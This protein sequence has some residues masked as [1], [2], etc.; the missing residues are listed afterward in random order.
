MRDLP[1]LRHREPGRREVLH[2]VRDAVRRSPARAA[3]RRTCPRPSSAPSAP[4]R[5]AGGAA[6]ATAAAPTAP[7]PPRD[8]LPSDAVAER[9]LVSVLFADLVG[10]TAFSEGRDAEEVR[11]L[12]DRYFETVREVIG[13]YGGTVEKFIGDAVMALWGAPIAHEDDAERAV[14]AGLDLVD[15]VRGSG[16]ALEVRAGVLTGEAAVTLGATEPGHG[17]RRHGQHGE[18]A[19][20]RRAAFDR[21][22]RRGDAARR[23]QARSSSSPPADQ[24]LKGKAEPGPRLARPAGRR[25][26]RRR[27]ADSDTLEAPFVGRDEELRQLKDLFHATGREG[28]PRLVSVIGPAGIGKSRL[29]WEFLKYVD[30]LVETRLVARRPEPGLRRGDHVLGARRDDP[31]PGPTPGD[32]RRGDHP[33]GDR[34]DARAARPRRV[35]AGLDRAGAAVAARARVGRRVAAALRGVA[36]VL[37]AARRDGAGGD[38]LRGLPPRRHGAARLRRPPDGV[39][40]QRPDPDPDPVPARS[41]SSGGPTGAPASAASPRSTSSRSR[42]PRCASSWR[43]SCPGCR[44]TRAT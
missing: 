8:A 33:G 28:R 38:G 25:P 40:A 5:M 29:A 16:P 4:R 44:T 14:R 10:F 3:A 17:R 32:R 39:V 1:E 34:G 11:E 13:R 21:A 7:A 43:A 2:G 22:R 18:P 15:A 24:V 30:G 42:P 36:D 35:R 19:P 26:A 12:Q 9:R 41:C 27:R 20:E 23:R 6:R 37:R 31:Q